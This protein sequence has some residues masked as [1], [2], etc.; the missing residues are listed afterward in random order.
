MGRIHNSN[1]STSKIDYFQVLF[2]THFYLSV[3]TQQNNFVY[4]L[5]RLTNLHYTLNGL[6]WMLVNNNYHNYCRIK[7]AQIDLLDSCRY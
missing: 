7:E 3:G 1:M 6:Y 5:V 2:K 4:R